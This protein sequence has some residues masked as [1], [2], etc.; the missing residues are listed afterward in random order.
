M[1]K[2]ELQQQKEEI[3]RLFSSAQSDYAEL[4]EIKEE[5]NTIRTTMRGRDTETQNKLVNITQLQDK[6]QRLEETDR[7]FAQLC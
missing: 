4:Q 2:E 6:A 3:E 1:T 7:D 5:A